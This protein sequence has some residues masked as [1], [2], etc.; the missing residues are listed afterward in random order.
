MPNTRAPFPVEL[1]R[2]LIDLYTFSDE[3]VLDPFM[4][5]GATAIA[6]VE[7]GR[8]FVGYEIS[9]EY[10]DVASERLRGV[11]GGPVAT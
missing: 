3:V 2:R 7:L 1:P 6:A 10:V 9:Q 5:S 4:G 11:T 8:S